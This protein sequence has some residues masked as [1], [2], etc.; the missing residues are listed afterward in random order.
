MKMDA[1]IT[2]STEKTNRLKNTSKNEEQRDK[3]N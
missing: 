3:V 1:D 2:K